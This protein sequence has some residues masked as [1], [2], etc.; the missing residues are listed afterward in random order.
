[1]V[2]RGFGARQRGT[3]CTVWRKLLPSYRTRSATL[4][5]SEPPAYH[6]KG[7]Y[8]TCCKKTS[9]LRSWRW[10]KVCP[11]TCWAYH[12]WSIKLLLLHLVGFYFTL[13]TLM[14]LGQTQIKF[15]QVFVSQ[16]NTSLL[17]IWNHTNTWPC[18]ISW[19]Y[20]ILKQSSINWQDLK[21]KY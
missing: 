21:F 5:R 17:L 12:W 10:A 16:M 6:T 19:P 8:T 1:M 13:T 9:V 3:M 20:P 18:I 7:H 2:G 11:E 4:P 14:M 15:I